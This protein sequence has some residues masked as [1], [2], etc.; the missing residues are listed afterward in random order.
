MLPAIGRTLTRLWQGC[1][2][3]RAGL[4]SAIGKRSAIACAGLLAALCTGC[5]TGETGSPSDVSESGM[6]VGGRVV[7][8]VGG[9]VE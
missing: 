2:Q 5:A 8:D 4:A 1:F 7:S 9:A 6:T 3:G